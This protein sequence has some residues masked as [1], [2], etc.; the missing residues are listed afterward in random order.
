MET[1]GAICAR[2][3]VAQDHK[4]YSQTGLLSRQLSNRSRGAEHLPVSQRATLSFRGFVGP[5]LFDLQVAVVPR[6]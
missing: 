4:I 2:L 1:S 3:R 5:E 6:Y